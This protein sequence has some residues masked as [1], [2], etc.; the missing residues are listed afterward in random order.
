M[1]DIWSLQFTDVRLNT[2]TLNQAEREKAGRF[3]KQMDQENYIKSH[4]FLREVLSHYAPTIAP[5]TWTFETNAFGRPSIC[6]D[7]G[8]SFYFNLSHTRS[9]AY[10]ILSTNP[11]CGIDVE[12]GSEMLIS[13]E[14]L[15][16]VLASSEKAY[17]DS[18]DQKKHLFY[19]YWT[20]K[21]AHLKALGT[22]LSVN[23]NT[24]TFEFDEGELI[25]N[26]ADRHYFTQTKANNII[27]SFAIL[28]ENNLS[29]IKYYSQKNLCY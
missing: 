7:H 25:S 18:V 4:W 17:Y 1:V 21:E 14:M 3:L 19:T 22:G 9:C 27:V 11:Q 5:A 8:V 6:A 20:L 13:E 24:I 12:E 29:E 28:N 10:I 15:S 23:P 16:M 2:Q 26:H